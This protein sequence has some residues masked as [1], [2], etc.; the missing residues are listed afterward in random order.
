[1]KVAV[2]WLRS[3]G[4]FES[5]SDR[6]LADV[7]TMAGLEVEEVHG[8]GLDTVF[9]TKVTPNRGDWLSIF[10]VARE[11]SAAATLPLKRQIAIDTPPVASKIGDF[12]VEVQAPGLC[13]RFGVAILH[14]VQPASSPKF[15]QDRLVLSGMRPLNVIVDITNYVMIELGQPLHAYDLRFL[16]SNK[17]V[18]RRAQN[19][20]RLITLDGT[21]RELSD[22]VL[23]IADSSF[24]VGIAGVMGGASSEV[25]SAT[26]SIVLEAAHFDAGVVR[27]GAKQL[28]ISTE[29][30]YRFE[31]YV[32]PALV[33]I[34][35]ARAIELLTKYAGLTCEENMIDTAPSYA[36]HRA[37]KLRNART[38]KILGLELSS[39]QIGSALRRLG[40]L[41]ESDGDSSNVLVP[42]FRPD[43]VKEIDLIEEV[44]RMIGYANL[45]ETLPVLQG[46]GGGDFEK[47]AFDSK[48]RSCLVGQGL[49]EA[50]S[51]TLGAASPFESSNTAGERVTVKSSLSK[52]LSGLRKTLLPHLLDALALNLRH[53]AQTVWMFEVGKVFTK[54]GIGQFTE[55]RH[56]SAVTCGGGADYSTS[57]GLVENLLLALNITGVE[58]QSE[59]VACMHPGRSANVVVDRIALGYVAEIDPFQASKYINLP[60]S[61]GRIAVF[62]LD[63]E[64]LRKIASQHA[65]RRYVSLPKFPSV[66][67]DLALLFDLSVAYGSIETVVKEAAGE[68]LE[69]VSLLSV[70]TGEKIPAGKK[71]VAIRLVLRSNEATLTEQAAEKTVGAVREALVERS[72]ASVR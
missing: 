28:G 35:L 22:E 46:T 10:G 58:F 54:E 43:L 11:L 61:T 18:V 55:D 1:M 17:L 34:A 44:G 69:A 50:Y 8:E 14:G 60:P 37:I 70:Y 62:E 16:H 36:G 26:T 56:V 29:A 68:L 65:L 47:G 19:D 45:P 48:L 13:P 4:D 27:R 72:A 40:M 67:R 5:L 9:L 71:S 3:F 23:V 30:S 25:S 51:H 20:E 42:S 12:T 32:D 24:P 57:K 2:E 53:G 33:P 59:P 21:E 64:K 49:V 38:N 7:L 39:D 63:A 6:Q 66:T 52:E 31:R 15:I 41:V